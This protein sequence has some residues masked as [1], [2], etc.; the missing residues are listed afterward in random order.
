MA[1]SLALGGIGM[2]ASGLAANAQVAAPSD[3]TAIGLEEVVVTARRK[4]ERLQDVPVAVTAATGEQLEQRSV[5]GVG[6]LSSF[7]PNLRLSQESRGGSISSVSLRGMAAV[8]LTIAND[9]A[10]GIYF[11]EVPIGRSAGTVLADLQDMESVQVLRGN[12]GTLFGRNNT[13]G[14]ILLTPNR[15]N[16]NEVE[17]NGALTF[18]NYGLDE[19]AAVVS[20]PLVDGKVG[21]RLAYKRGDRDA[22]GKRFNAAGVDQGDG[23]GARNRQGGRASLRWAPTDTLTFDLTY[24]FSRVNEAGLGVVRVFPAQVLPAGFEFGD[25]ISAVAPESNFNSSGYSFHSL[26]DINDDTALKIIVGYRELA[27]HNTFDADGSIATSVD[28]TQEG[29]QSQFSSEINLS[30]VML[31]DTVSYL[32]SVDYVLGAFYFSEQGLD[33]SYLPARPMDERKRLASRFTRA[34]GVNTSLA[35][36]GQVEA[37]FTPQ[38]SAWLGLRYTVDNRDAIQQSFSLGNCILVGNPAG[39]KIEGSQE[40]GYGSWSVGVRHA[41]SDAI[42]IYARAARG[43]RAGG[44]DDTPTTIVSFSPE[45]LQDYEI[46]LKADWLDGMLR[47]NLAIF[48]GDFSNI[49]RSTL[50][51]QPLCTPVGSGACAPYTSVVNVGEG[52]VQGVE[53]EATLRPVDGLVLNGS[54]G[55]LEAEVDKWTG[56][57]PSQQGQQFPGAPKWS[58]SLAATYTRD[59]GDLGEGTVRLDYGWKDDVIIGVP[60][61]PLV[62]QE[63]VGLFNARIAFRP[64]V[65]GPVEPEIAIWGKN[66]TDEEYY[67][68]SLIQ[69]GAT[70]LWQID[71]PLTYGITISA[72]Y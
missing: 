7:T 58:Y 53:F 16:L 24:D 66:L 20:V 57:L 55:Y 41:F 39:C 10:V 70:A 63:A 50:V 54:L 49:Q 12:Q 46:G 19:Q 31:R 11:D 30:G 60:V 26:W 48:Y 3:G 28:N 6:D 21:L 23:Y 32:D 47:T 35:A 65:D 13:G 59:I 9:P 14:A 72:R 51:Q 34:T 56:P 43:Q 15:P 36:Y 45:V 8:N 64:K 22:T 4:E 40:Y 18:G 69:G 5:R 68:S 61:S 33:S 2:L 44:L 37:H 29:R 52:H 27:F 1:K 42:S 38:T 17:A 71:E 62:I 25:A 67:T